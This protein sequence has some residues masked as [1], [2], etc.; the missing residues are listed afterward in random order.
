MLRPGTI[1]GTNGPLACIV[2]ACG[3]LACG[4]FALTAVLER[5]QVEIV[6]AENGREAISQL[7]HHPDTDLVL[8]DVMMPN[9]DGLE[10]TRRIRAIPEFEALPI[11]AVTAKAMPGDR[12][13]CLEA[14]ASDYLSKPVDMDHLRAMIRVWLAR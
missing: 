6:T 14:G 8:M 1:R 3:V 5:H 10:T 12:D 13:T 4:N 11:I 7:E 2:L 9:V